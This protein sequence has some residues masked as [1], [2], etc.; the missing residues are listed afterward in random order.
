MKPV[1]FGQAG[2]FAREPIRKKVSKEIDGGLA[3]QRIPFLLTG[4]RAP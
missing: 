1:A 4:G 2:G 3:G